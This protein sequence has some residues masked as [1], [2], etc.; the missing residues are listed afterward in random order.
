MRGI[1]LEVA[2]SLNKQSAI[3]TAIAAASI[4]RVLPYTGFAPV[5]GEHPDSNSDKDYYGKG[6]SFATRWNP[7]TK[8]FVIGSR[9][10]DLS[11][12]SALFAPAFVM[13]DLTTTNPSTAAPTVY[14]H[15]FVFQ[16]PSTNE[17]CL[18]TS[19]I[20]K[21]AGVEQNLISGAVIEQF[22]LTGSLKDHVKIG[23]Q[24]FAR[25]MVANAAAM[26]ALSAESSFFTTLGGTF[27]FGAT[28]AA[29][30][31]STKLTQW[32]MTFNQN[33]SPWFLPGNPAGQKDLLT[34]AKVGKQSVSGQI[35]V[36]FEST[37]QRTLFR[38]NTECTLS[39][40]LLGS[41]IGTTG[42]Y[43]TITL[44]I[45]HLKIPSESFAEEQEQATL[46]IPFTEQSVLKATGDDYV[47]MTVRCD[48]DD[49]KLL[50][51]A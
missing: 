7:I 28:G 19:L 21:L 1:D 43:Y 10:F 2:F 46:T 44:T 4:D 14:D 31:I 41:Q 39:I 40:V 51:A 25:Q 48:E 30:D 49:T 32:N 29:I 42:L 38:N 33:P 27:T 13:G 35:V 22:T 47:S 23:W 17:E 50:V 37:A 26:P 20:E 45:P 24:G 11:N 16:D 3:G 36:L 8:R 12:L 5:V 6:H 15:K 9:E 34:K 18:Y